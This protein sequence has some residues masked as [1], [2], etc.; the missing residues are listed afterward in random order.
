M[1]RKL[2]Q[3]SFLDHL[4]RYSLALPPAAA[5]VWV[6]GETVQQFES[7]ENVISELVADNPQMR[8]VLTSASPATLAFLRQWHPGE[9]AVPLPW[10]PVT[11]R[12]I[13]K[14]NPHLLVLL[15]GGRS[16]G[17]QTLAEARRSGVPVAVMGEPALHNGSEAAV[18]AG[19]V[20]RDPDQ[21]PEHVL[22]TLRPLVPPVARVPV[23][24]AWLTGTLRDRVGQSRLWRIA[25]RPL[26]GRRID[27]WETL[28]ERLK[29]PR[30]VLCLGN[31]PS[32]ENPRLEGLPHDCLMRVNWRWRDRGL[33]THPQVVFVGDAATIHR[34]SRCIY[35][36]WNR[37]IE[38]AMLLRHLVVRGPRRM[39]FVT[40][41]RLLPLIGER[42]WPARPS[43][44]AL[45]IV[46][47]AGLAPE[48]LIISGI[49]LFQ[50]PAGPYPG[51]SV[52]ANKYSRA[53]SRDVELALIDL[54][55]RNYQG[56]VII[57]SDILRDSLTQYR[58]MRNG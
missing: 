23:A 49:D 48:R 36:F 57:L 28:R 51:G 17:Q 15:D 4:Q 13:G 21:S 16:F 24:D 29:H 26:T 5:S 31:G 19:L 47:A 39:E 9:Q 3:F 38:S 12:F 1:D 22:K 8:L 58:E 2:F 34:A 56:E 30:T 41:E 18:P 50:H 46:T 32:S 14:L 10:G 33:L 7:A 37:S 52:T 44:G 43:N 25:S 20:F 53:H 11:S 54:A 45:M 27:D 35:G 6:H 55:L 42:T 40:L